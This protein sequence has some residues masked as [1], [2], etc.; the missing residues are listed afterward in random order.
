MASLSQ[1]ALPIS[2]NSS[3][4]CRCSSSV[5]SWSSQVTPL[6]LSLRTAVSAPPATN[7]HSL[8]G[9]L[10]LPHRHPCN[11]PQ[12]CP[13][14]MTKLAFTLAPWA[15]QIRALK[16]IR[17]SL[18]DDSMVVATGPDHEKIVKRAYSTTLSYLHFIGAAITSKK[19]FTFCT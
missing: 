4:R 12:G 19:C 10:G 2:G 18:A 7:Y 9:G 15:K 5:I 13:L 17:R 11:I 1:E 8:A 6:V 16:A 14:S 3:T